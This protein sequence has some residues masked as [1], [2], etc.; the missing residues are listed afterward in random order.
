M[1]KTGYL[2]LF[3][4]VIAI[5]IPFALAKADGKWGHWKSFDKSSDKMEGCPYMKSSLTEDQR[6]EL[7]QVMQEERESGASWE[8]IK[9]AKL[10]KMQEFGIEVNEDFYNKKWSKH[11]GYKKNHEG[12]SIFKRMGFSL[13]K[14]W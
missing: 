6:E 10:E 1:N 5:A 4:L 8:E 12:K 14:Y 13:P 3:L 11:K 7:Y 2:L 9:A